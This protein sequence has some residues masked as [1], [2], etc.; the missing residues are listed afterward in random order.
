MTLCSRPGDF[1]EREL[2]PRAPGSSVS[3]GLPPPPAD[4]R[5]FDRPP[6][7]GRAGPRVLHFARRPRASTGGGGTCPRASTRTSTCCARAREAPR[8]AWRPSSERL[9]YREVSGRPERPGHFQREK[10]ALEIHTRG[11]RYPGH[12]FPGQRVRLTFSSGRVKTIRDASDTAVPALILEPEL[13]GSVF[14]AELEDRTVIRLADAPG[15]LV[16]AILVTEDRDFYRHS[17]VSVR[18]LF[19][20][21]FAT[22]R[23]GMRQGGSTLTQQLVKNLYLSPERT[24]RRKAVEAVM[25]VVLDARYSK[26]EILEAY[27]NEIYLGRRGSIGITGVG[28]AARSYF[29]KE[30]S[31]L[32]LAES[33]TLAGMIRAPNA[34]S[35]VPQSRTGEAAARPRARAD[36]GGRSHRRGRDA[37]AMAEPLV[38]REPNARSGRGPRTSSTSSRASSRSATA[39]QMQTEGLLIYTTLD[40]DLQ[41]AAQRAVTQGLEALEKTLPAPGLGGQGGAAPGRLHRARAADRQRAGAR[42]RA[43]LPPL[44]VQSRHP[45]APPA[46]QPLQTVRL[47]R[48]LRAAGP[49]TPRSRRLRSSWTRRSPSR[50]GS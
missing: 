47:P 45:G 15:S 11:F 40:V 22:L 7:L 38:P 2:F 16:D 46:G 30:V 18:R 9:F 49:S 43:R 42:R 10:D 6:P 48:R 39:R 32:D 20:A 26:D 17:G 34:Y 37:A 35:P 41:Q 23:G 25:A 4:P 29:G 12:S 44:P 5:Q 13:L 31:D 1:R 24:V 14:S 8:T 21:L 50:G 3:L 27:L 33:A 36:A 19:G 28:E